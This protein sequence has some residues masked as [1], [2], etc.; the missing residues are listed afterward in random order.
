MAMLGIMKVIKKLCNENNLSYWLDYGTLLGAV[1]HKGFIPWDGDTDICMLREDYLKIIPLLK[2]YYSNSDEFFVRE[3]YKCKNNTLNL[4]LRICNKGS[5]RYGVDIFPVDRYFK[6]NL[7][8]KEFENINSLAHDARKTFNRECIENNFF[9]ENLTVLRLLINQIS[10]EIILKNN[11]CA[12][13]SKDNPSLFYGLDFDF[14]TLYPKLSFN[15]NTIFPLKTL[16]FEEEQFFVPNNTEE[17]LNLHYGQNYM[18][19]PKKFNT[20]EDRINEYMRELQ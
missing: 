1:R 17:L 19:F 6:G 3:I 15:Y 2:E 11:V 13:N 20:D 8:K 9:Q 16:L 10:K 4:Q 12:C 14:S 7:D 18:M 5:G